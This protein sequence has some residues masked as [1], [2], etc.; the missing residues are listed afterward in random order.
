[1]AKTL[2]LENKKSNI[3]FVSAKGRVHHQWQENHCEIG[4]NGD[5]PM[6]LSKVRC[7]CEKVCRTHTLFWL[8]YICESICYMGGLSGADYFVTLQ[9]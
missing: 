9:P 1:M 6:L 7:E 3:S 5:S 2:L 8:C 4:V